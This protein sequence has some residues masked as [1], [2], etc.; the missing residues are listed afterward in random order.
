[1]TFISTLH[2]DGS[3]SEMDRFLRSE[4]YSLLAQSA[5]FAILS[6]AIGCA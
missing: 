1:M 6:Q 2:D 3:R 5:W 4:G